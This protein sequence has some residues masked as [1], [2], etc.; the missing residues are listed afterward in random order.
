MIVATFFVSL[1]VVDVMRRYAVRR[2]M[3]D[4]P[5][6]RSSHDVPRPRG[7]GAAIALAFVSAV[8][9]LF[10]SGRLEA[11][12]TLALTVGGCAIAGVGFLDDRQS[13][14]AKTRLAVHGAAAGW[15]VAMLGGGTGPIAW[16][17][18]ALTVLAIVWGINLFNFMDGIDG[19]AGSEAV[20]ISS[21][22]AWL[23]FL[24]GADDGM[25][26]AMLCLAAAS[27]GF[28]VWN[29]P[30]ARIFMGDVGS[31]FLGFTLAALAFA[32]A[33]HGGV[34]VEAWLILGGVFVVDS[35]TTLLRRF[36]RGDPWLEPHRI[37]AYQHLARRFASHR[38]TTLVVLSID[39][40]WL[41]PWAY[42]ATCFPRSGRLCVVGALTPLV[43]SALWAGAGKKEV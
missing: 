38:R 27:L 2:N 21:S 35:T 8:L 7:G 20:F 15:F 36:F 26:I 33:R 32:T 42:L 40:F 28:L 34:R 23:N 24:C 14:S 41:L 31:G 30:P 4:L 16:I 22:G 6:M 18:S 29:W 10:L 37:H 25:S 9:T 19:I 13:L 3:I 1:V 39:V 11:R 12:V 17:G 5:G 43:A